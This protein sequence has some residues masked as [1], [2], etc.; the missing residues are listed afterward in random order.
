MKVVSGEVQDIVVGSATLSPSPSGPEGERGAEV[1]KGEGEGQRRGGEGHERADGGRGN[2]G[3]VRAVVV[4]GEPLPAEV[5]VVAMGPW[6]SRLRVVSEVTS[7]SGLKANSIVVRP[8]ARDASDASAPTITNHMLFTRFVDKRGSVSEPE[9]YPRPS[10][11]V[12]VC[13]ATDYEAVV[14]DS[15]ADIQPSA[16]AAERRVRVAA[17]V[18]SLLHPSRSSVE[19]QQACF[20]PSSADGLPVIGALPGCPGAYIATGHSCWGILNSLATGLCVAEL[21]VEGRAKS[22]NINAFD[23]ARFVVKG[24]RR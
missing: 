19:A 6:S 10:G 9:V 1:E 5:A 24:G 8:N 22:A 16:G 15:P 3:R 11:E 4:D 13:G 14:P 23:P 12:Y 7:V 17:S 2:E 18:S 20:L 21:I